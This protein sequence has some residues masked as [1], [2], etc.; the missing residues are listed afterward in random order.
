[1]YTETSIVYMSVI[2]VEVVHIVKCIPVEVKYRKTEECYLQLPV[3][4]ENQSFSLSPRTHILRGSPYETPGKK[5]LFNDFCLSRKKRYTSMIFYTY[6]K[7]LLNNM[8]KK[9][10]QNFP[11]WRRYSWRTGMP[12]DWSSWTACRIAC[13]I[14]VWNQWNFFLSCT[15]VYSIWTTKKSKTIENSLFC[16]VKIKIYDFPQWNLLILFHKQCKKLIKL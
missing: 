3:F 4:R 2:A 1:M 7:L 10:S 6:F 8:A 13:V 14:F 9:L 16:S 12:H 5:V 11:K 15:L